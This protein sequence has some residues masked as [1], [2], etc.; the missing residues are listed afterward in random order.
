MC[1]IATST[2]AAAALAEENIAGTYRLI[3]SQ[4]KIVDTGEVLDTY[5]KN[6]VGFIMYGNDG[7]MLALITYDNRK[8]PA[9]IAKVTDADKV[10]LYNSMMSYGGT[11]KFDGKKVEHHIDVSYNQ[12]WTG[13]TTVRD[14]VKD[15]DRLIYTTRPAPFSGDGKVSITTLIWEKVK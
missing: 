9:D 5:G 11:Y 8:A 14:I 6:P 3:S 1:A 10:G 4:R 15:G 12:M 7:R 2:F 13:T